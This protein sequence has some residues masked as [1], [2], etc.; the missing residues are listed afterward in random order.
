M[1]VCEAEADLHEAAA[2]GVRAE[3]RVVPVGGARLAAGLVWWSA[4]PV[5]DG[6]LGVQGD[7]V[8]C[9]VDL[10]S[11]DLPDLGEGALDAVSPHFRDG[12]EA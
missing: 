8:L 4:D 7:H 10:F 1:L 12:N 9:C 5:R 2:V 3:L 6:E 11:E